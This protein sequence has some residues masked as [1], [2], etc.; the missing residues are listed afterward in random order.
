MK[1]NEWDARE[2]IKQINPSGEVIRTKTYKRIMPA[3][4]NWTPRKLLA[5]RTK[6]AKILEVPVEDL[7]CNI[8]ITISCCRYPKHQKWSRYFN[9]IIKRIIKKQ[10]RLN[11][12]NL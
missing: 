4:D 2:W 7:M 8:E 9:K 10:E 5:E 6:L 3:W 11:E 12:P 1:S